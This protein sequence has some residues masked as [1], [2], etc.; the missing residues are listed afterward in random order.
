MDTSHWGV[1]FVELSLAIRG[2]TVV[3]KSAR[4]ILERILDTNKLASKFFQ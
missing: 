2:L 1:H 3:T 4:N